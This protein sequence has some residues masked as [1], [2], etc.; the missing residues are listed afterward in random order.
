MGCLLLVYTVTG[1]AETGNT[2]EYSGTFQ[3]VDYST[4][5]L[6]ND[7][8]QGPNHHIAEGTYNTQTSHS[9]RG[10]GSSSSLS[11][12]H[13]LPLLLQTLQ[14]FRQLVL[15]LAVR[16]LPQAIRQ[17]AKLVP[18][19]LHLVAQLRELQT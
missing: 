17:Q 2:R 8:H 7:K 19:Q 13:R 1:I 4:P 5:V 11:G 3:K 18:A 9:L 15:Q 12:L 16:R 10:R 6:L 14:R